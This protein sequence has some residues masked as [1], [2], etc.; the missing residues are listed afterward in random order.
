[1]RLSVVTRSSAELANLLG[2]FLAGES[3]PGIHAADEDAPDVSKGIVFVCPG[4]GCQWHGMA[5][6][7]LQGEP[8]FRAILCECDAHVR[9]LLGWSLIDELTCDQAESR[10]DD[11]EVT[12]PAIISIDIA[13]AA[14]WRSLGIQPAAVIGQSTG[15]IA[16]AYIAGALDLED[17]MR[18]ICA[19][20]RI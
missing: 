16:A 20:G 10:F 15:E 8:V 9:Q 13:I 19:Y 17:T 7:L 14:W 18:V 12:L 5:R 3:R 11:I 2:A 1:H 4:Q 6:A